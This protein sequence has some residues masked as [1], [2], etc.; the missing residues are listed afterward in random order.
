MYERHKDNALP[1]G[2]VHT[3]ASLQS[4]VRIWSQS[5][6]FKQYDPLKLSLDLSICDDRAGQWK[7]KWNMARLIRMR[8]RSKRELFPISEHLKV[9]QEKSVLCH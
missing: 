3:A 9:L 7:D 2:Y 8:S 5:Q 6:D 4:C 1:L